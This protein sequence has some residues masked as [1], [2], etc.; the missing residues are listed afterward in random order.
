VFFILSALDGALTLWGLGLGAI[1]EA[2][3]FM[4]WLIEKNPYVFMFVKLFL[5]IILG[6][7]LWR[8]MNKSFVTYSLGLILAVYSVVL[9]LHAYW[10]VNTINRYG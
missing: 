5:P 8:I 1:K 10:V 3:P 4:K 9:V 6:L 2:N 7:M